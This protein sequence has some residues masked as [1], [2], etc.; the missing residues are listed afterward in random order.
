MAIALVTRIN[1][2]A[3][4]D[5]P[6]TNAYFAGCFHVLFSFSSYPL[7]YFKPKN[8]EETINNKL[9]ATNNPANAIAKRIKPNTYLKYLLFII[10]PFCLILT[11]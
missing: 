9:F 3:I 7:R 8:N 5:I 10:Y 1:K 4:K 2:I 11:Q 6:Y